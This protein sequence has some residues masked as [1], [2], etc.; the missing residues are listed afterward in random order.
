MSNDRSREAFGK[1]LDFL[2]EKGLM[3]PSTAQ[4]RKVSSM[5]LLGIL[6]PDEASD[7][8]NIDIDELAVRFNNLHGQN[9]NP[10]SVR[11]YR[12][13][14]RSSMDDFKSYLKNPLNFK[15]ALQSRDR[16][17]RPHKENGTTGKV[18]KPADETQRAQPAT[19]PPVMAST[20]IMPIPIRS[21][22][23]ILI[24]GLPHDLTPAEAKKIAGVITALAVG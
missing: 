14:L 6:S 2:G 19:Q 18:Q 20:N 11:A 15:P 12:S 10:D 4:T 16:A 1:F 22:L 21:D 17:S 3:S 5:K 24:H 7:V 23:T 13:R 9:Y 8:T